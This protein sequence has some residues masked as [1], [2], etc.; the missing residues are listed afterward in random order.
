MN[1]HQTCLQA[2]ARFSG[3]VLLIQYPMRRHQ[4]AA[5]DTKFR[6]VFSSS[7]AT[8]ELHARPGAA[9][10]LPAA[11]GTAEPLAEYNARASTRRLAPPPRALP[12]NEPAW[13]VAR[14]DTAISD[15]SR[16]VETARREP[17]GM[18]FT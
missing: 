11:A 8:D 15:A 18:S 17:F 13:P 2:F 1:Q 14:M 4:T 7:H 3:N 6:I 9:R 16:F 12:V 5:A 10:I